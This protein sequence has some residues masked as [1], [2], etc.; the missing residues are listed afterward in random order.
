MQTSILPN[1]AAPAY[2][3][4]RFFQQLSS[5]CYAKVPREISVDELNVVLGL[6]TVAALA[7]GAAFTLTVTAPRDCII[8]DLQ[9]FA[10]SPDALITQINVAG[11]ALV[12][13]LQVPVAVF[14][15]GNQARPSFDLP[16]KGGTTLQ[17]IGNNGSTAAAI[18]AAAFSID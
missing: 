6:G 14:T 18:V 3:R 1:G 7:A 2:R 8:R 11:D 13:G 10:T 4:N 17:I 15:V 12:L 5:S 9:M 16:V